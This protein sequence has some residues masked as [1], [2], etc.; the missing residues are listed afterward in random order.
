MIPVQISTPALITA[1]FLASAAPAAAQDA[2]A[3][4]QRNTAGLPTHLHA[5]D[6]M[7]PGGLMN[8]PTDLVWDTYG[9]HLTREFIVDEAYPGGGAA[10]RVMIAQPGEVY[11]GGLNIPLLAPVVSGDQL[12]IGFFAR[13]ISSASADGQGRVQVR[14]Q[15]N[16]EPYPGFGEEL[17]SIGPEW[18]FYEVTAQADRGFRNDAIVAL[19]FG[20][21]RQ[22]VEIGQAIVVSGTTYIVD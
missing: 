15:Q 14:F 18:G 13:T 20:L 3:A 22:T 1:L 12:T 10:L 5:I 19:Q 2:A 6:Q 4:E 16:R 11:S 17:V 8:D 7:L 9:T 21:Q